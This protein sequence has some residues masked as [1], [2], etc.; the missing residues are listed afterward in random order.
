MSRTIITCLPLG[1]CELLLEF[2]NLLAL[3]VGRDFVA[4]CLGRLL[5]CQ[6][7]NGIDVGETHILFQ[8]SVLLLSVDEVEEDVESASEDERQE[9]TEAG[10][11]CIPLCAVTR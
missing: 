1:R 8:L 9:E 6:L 7:E 2:C 11:V 5:T 10:K 4:R 3:F